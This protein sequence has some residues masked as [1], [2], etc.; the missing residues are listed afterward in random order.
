[1]IWYV[2]VSTNKDYILAIDASSS[3]MAK[4]FIPNRLE[5]AKNA[6]TNFIDK[7][8]INSY[9]GIISFSGVSFV[10]HP[11]TQEKNLAKEAVINIQAKTIGGTDLGNAIITATNLLTPSKKARSIILITDGRS[12]IGI[13]EETA[14][15]YAI[16][17]KAT[18]NTIGIGSSNES[19]NLTLGIEE[20]I[21]VKMA[22]LTLGNY[23]YA[24]NNDDLKDIYNKIIA[25]QK[26]GKNPF[27]LS[28][29]LLIA[30]LILLLS[31]WLLGTTIYR[32][33]P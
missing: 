23:Y 1:T 30:A 28:F 19:D 16:E 33:I 14:I 20:E 17:H 9:I 22:N 10:E 15:S 26:I 21:L 6:A 25:S 12:N 4:D 31:D 7:L 3:M 11:L 29:I 32:R 13:A 8:P 18:I 5:A 27:D 2:G 24:Q